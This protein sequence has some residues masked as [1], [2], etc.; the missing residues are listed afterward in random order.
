MSLL[1]ASKSHCEEQQ[2]VIV[3]SENRSKHTAYNVNTCVVRHYKI[4]GEVIPVNKTNQ[5]KKCD[6]LLLNDDD[7]QA[8][9]IEL[10]GIDVEEAPKQIEATINLLKAELAKYSFHSRIVCKRVPKTKPSSWIKHDV[11]CR[12]HGWTFCHGSN[13]NYSENI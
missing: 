4:D 12:K 11:L 1:S 6:F 7:K 8:Y 3:S 13:G 10:K 2:K 5:T 9:F